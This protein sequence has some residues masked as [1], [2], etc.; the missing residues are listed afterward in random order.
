MNLG[1]CILQPQKITFAVSHRNLAGS[2][3]CVRTVCTRSQPVQI[4]LMTCYSN[5][6]WSQYNF[7]NL[8]LI[9]CFHDLKICHFS[10][11]RSD[12]GQMFALSWLITWFAHVI[13]DPDSIFRVFDFFLGTHPLMPIY[14][15][16]AVSIN[17]FDG[18]SSFL[19]H[20]EGEQGSLEE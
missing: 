19:K 10:W 2:T 11:L 16:A 13:N 7:L 6:C 15:G 9:T 20:F 12:V 3:G 18:T 5:G 8:F 1:D 17:Y 14:L 4:W